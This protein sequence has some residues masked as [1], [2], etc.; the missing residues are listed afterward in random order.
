MGRGS[1][2]RTAGVVR[3]ESLLVFLQ[4]FEF[5]FVCPARYR[6][7]AAL[8]VSA[9]A[10]GTQ[11]QAN[12]VLTLPLND[13][14]RIEQSLGK[15]VL[16]EPVPAAILE[17][18]A[19]YLPLATGPKTYRVVGSQ[20]EPRQE[21]YHSFPLSK[22]RGNVLWHY[23]AGR[24]EIGLLEARAGGSFFMSGIQDL[25]EGVVTRY[26]PPE[27][28]LLKG[29]V[30][31]EQQALE[32]AVR[33]YDLHHA[34]ELAHEGTL[35]VTY[36]YAGAYRVKVPAGVFDAIV[37]KSTFRGKIGPAALEDI[38]YRFFALG[39]G[40]VASVEVRD[41]SAFFVYRRHTESAKMLLGKPG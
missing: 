19:R 7:F 14:L 20:P 30:P 17:E 32:M 35:S 21:T 40:M 1:F 39:V 24:D 11:A 5:N 8:A 29:L 31:G 22:E 36:Q 18:P 15:G 23:D 28:I 16:G 10:Y 13:R 4:M 41:V 12:P 37:I 9:L 25:R 27:P 26:S 2:R 33:V 38:Q 34:D 6:I 3:I